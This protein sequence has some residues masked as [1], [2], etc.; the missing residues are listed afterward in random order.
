MQREDL[1]TANLISAGLFGDGAA[2]VI[3]AG[4]NQPSEGPQILATRSVFYPDT[5]HIMGWDISEK[6]FQI[7]LSPEVPLMAARHLGNDVDAFLR[8]MNIT[9][10]DIG[11]WILR[12]GGQGPR[13]NG[14]CSRPRQR[15]SRLVVGVPSKDWQSLVGLSA[16]GARGS[17]AS[18]PPSNRNIQSVG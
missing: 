13:S 9:R 1:T 8:E 4:A 14:L 11:S 15:G 16:P 18:S 5:E 17:H 10:A 12:T 3:I 6:G 7:V 2:A